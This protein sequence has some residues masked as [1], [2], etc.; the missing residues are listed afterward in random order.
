MLPPVKAAAVVIVLPSVLEFALGIGGG[1]RV[2][3]VLIRP[4]W[5]FTDFSPP[6]LGWVERVC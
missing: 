5:E 4:V 2:S 6:S 1:R 3:A